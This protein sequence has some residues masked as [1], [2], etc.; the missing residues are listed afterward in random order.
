MKYDMVQLANTV[1]N[2]TGIKQVSQKT[3][4]RVGR[5]TGVRRHT[6][7]SE[8]TQESLSQ[9]PKMKGIV[10]GSRRISW[11]LTSIT[12]SYMIP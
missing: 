4:R 1:A 2:A 3:H 9:N 12:K 7:E 10:H 5:H 8:D 11:V 6:G